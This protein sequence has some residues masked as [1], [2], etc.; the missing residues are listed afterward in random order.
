MSDPLIRLCNY[1]VVFEPGKKQTILTAQE[2]LSWLTNWLEEMESLP[3]DLQAY[4][5]NIEAAKHLLN[6][7]CEL[8]I[9]PGF[10]LQWFAV[11][12]DPDEV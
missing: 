10:S 7:A 9:S 5:S 2:T 12:L 3:L 4:Y 6:T 8:D 11:R 1:Y